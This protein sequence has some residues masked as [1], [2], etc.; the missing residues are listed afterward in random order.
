MR[1]ELPNKKRVHAPGLQEIGLHAE[2]GN[3]VKTRVLEKAG[4]TWR[5]RETSSFAENACIHQPSKELAY[6]RNAA[7]L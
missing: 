6:T 3:L 5:T 1:N 7:D 2:C 4:G